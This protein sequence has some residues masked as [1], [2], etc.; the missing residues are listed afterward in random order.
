METIPD[1]NGYMTAGFI[2]AFLVMGLYVLSIYIRSKNL[3]RDLETLEDME[4]AE[5]K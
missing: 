3:R 2:I 5:K 4:T 1:T